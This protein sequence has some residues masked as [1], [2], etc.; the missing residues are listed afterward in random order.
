MQ[1]LLDE[2]AIVRNKTITGAKF[3]V[4]IV[5]VQN[6]VDWFPGCK[7]IHLVRDPRA[8][9][10]SM[11][12]TGMRSTTS[13][14]FV[15]K[16]WIQWIK[17]IYVC[18]QYKAAL[19]AHKRYQSSPDYCFLKFE[20]LIEHPEDEIRKL[21][22]FCD[23]EFTESMLSPPTG[24]G[25]FYGSQFERSRGF[26]KQSLDRWKERIPALYRRLLEGILRKEMDEF[27]YT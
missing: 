18:H 19:R 17:F 24:L 5:Y 4:N 6:L 7:L 20:D 2:Y 25:S 9:F 10:I 26:D 15:K 3:P 1:I 12:N 16:Y 23:I 22:S 27:G 8:I 11:I 14:V 13:F 21:C